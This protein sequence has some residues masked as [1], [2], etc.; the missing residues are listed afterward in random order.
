M[1]RCLI[2]GADVSKGYAEF[3]LISADKKNLEPVFRLDDGRE[4]H[5]ILKAFF[6]KQRAKHRAQRIV[7]AVE[8]TGGYE[9]NWV[10]CARDPSVSA[11]V[12]AFR[13]NPKVTRHEY[14]AQKRGSIDDGV[15]AQ[16]IA[17]HVAKNLE[18]YQPG[19]RQED[20][21]LSAARSM[22]R[23]IASL[24]KA[25]TQ[26]KNALDKL[27]YRHLSPLLAAKP[28]SW[29][30]YFLN[31]LARYGGKR[32]ILAAAR[33]GFK[34]IKYV[35]AGKAEQI[36]TALGK[37]D[38]PDTMPM[39]KEAVRSKAAQIIALEAEIERLKKLFCGQAPVDEAQVKLL[40]T[41]KGM[42]R[43]AATVLLCFIGDWARF[44]EAAQ[45]AAFF[46]VNPRFKRSGDGGYKA[47]MSKQGSP[48]VRRELYL[49]AFRTLSQEDYLR[50]IYARQR[51]KGKEHDAAL[52]VLMHKL[53]R[54]IYGMLKNGKAFNP[55]TDQL[56]QASK[57]EAADKQ[58]A[59]QKDMNSAL[60][61]FQEES[62]DAPVSDRQR[63]KRKS[64]HEPQAANPAEC[65]GS[66]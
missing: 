16:A 23:H 35:P 2:L 58:T 8:S 45:M 38:C 54:I 43:Y 65:T 53:L 59:S 6:K 39:D 30:A 57:K 33:R 31:I 10:R 46:G 36:A 21:L 63:K 15:S 26:Q 56:N 40:C 11:F 28:N 62:P 48:L 34:S 61:R 37:G 9:D 42:G 13:I 3:T 51:A 12:Q 64:G 22:V 17:E 44:G 27:L 66:S 47:K 41:I 32:A 25:S 7:F 19:E 18:S 1:D 20:L 49:L 52:G 24:E 5:D 29:P 55:G 60:R 4:G 14:L 50:A